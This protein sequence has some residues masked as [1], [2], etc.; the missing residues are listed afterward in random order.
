MNIFISKNENAVHNNIDI[1]S[2]IFSLN[3]YDKR[4]VYT[5]FPDTIN[6]MGIK[7]IDSIY[8]DL[9]VIGLS[10]FA[11][12]KRIPRTFFA[13]NWTRELTV[14]IPV[15]NDVWEHLVD[16]INIMLSFLTGDKWYISFRSTEESFFHSVKKYRKTYSIPQCDSVCLF[17]GGLDSFCG[18]ITLLKKEKSPCLIG[19]NEYPKLRIKQENLAKM[20]REEFPD[21]NAE[22]VSF[23][24]GSRA[25]QY[26]D[27]KEFL[28]S[29]NTT[30]G[31]SLLFLC[32][33]L[34]MASVL[35]ENIPVYIPENGF[36]GLNVPLTNNR[37]GSCTTRTTHPHFL[38]MFRELLNN[39]GIKNKINN[40]FAY[41]TKRNIVNSVKD[42]E[43]FKRGY[44][45]TISCSHPCIHRYNKNGS[46]EYPINCGYCYPCIIRKSALLDVPDGNQGYTENTLSMQFIN[47]NS[48]KNIIDDLKAVISTIY[49]FEHID[50]K[51]LIR[52]IKGTGKLSFDEINKFKSVYIDS[53]NDIIELLSMDPKIKEYIGL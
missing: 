18:A 13:D 30:R 12:D 11:I 51:E 5:N 42:E 44:L 4:N 24:A 49:R 50:E 26:A 47:E 41:E 46:K 35:G 8:E 40:F 3:R 31:R 53:I 15:L 6:R 33:A 21:Q 19:H 27:G 2:I 25:P 29:E 37:K 32:V 45:E 48:H 16:H 28:G 52:L 22:F 7:D 39:V 23:T 9:F 34:V 20:F 1:D 36:I 14:N 38:N 17:S 43:A 10:V